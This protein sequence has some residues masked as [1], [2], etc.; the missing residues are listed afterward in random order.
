MKTCFSAGDNAPGSPFLFFTAVLFHMHVQKWKARHPA[1]S[2][3][4]RHGLLRKRHF[5]TRSPQASNM[6]PDAF[7]RSSANVINYLFFRY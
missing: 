5:F 4:P 2:V 6:P 7:D 3:I 1:R